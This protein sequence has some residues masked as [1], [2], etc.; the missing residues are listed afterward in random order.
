MLEIEA[1]FLEIDADDIRSRLQNLG[2]E[3]TYDGEIIVHRFAEIDDATKKLRLRYRVTTGVIDCTI[4][5]KVHTN[6]AKVKREE[7]CSWEGSYADFK[8]ESARLQSEGMTL[9]D[10]VDKQRETWKRPGITYELDTITDPIWIPTFLEIEVDDVSLLEESARELGLSMNDAK[11]W[12]MWKTIKHYRKK[13]A[14]LL[15]EPVLES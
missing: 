2:A 10:D 5:T 15:E 9:T 12:S 8:D 4:K 13:R 3:K 7:E 14:G 11:T 1:K 6:G